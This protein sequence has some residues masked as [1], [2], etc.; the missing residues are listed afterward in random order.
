MLVVGKSI[1]AGVPLAAYGMRTEIASLI[2]PPEQSR[3][4]SGVVVG[5]VSTGG[6]LFANA[7]SM[8]A[9]RAALLEVL[10]E[11]AFE[12]TAALG[13]RMA[14][15]LRAAIARAGLGWS[16][17]QVGGHAYYFFE[18]AP[19]R[20][21]AG[22]RAADDP[23][24]ARADPRVHGQPRSLGIGM[25]AGADRVG[26]ARRVARRPL[27][28]VLRRVPE[29]GHV[30]TL[31]RPR[32]VAV[33]GGGIAGLT[34]AFELMRAGSE[35]TV[36]QLGWRLGG[37]GAS[38]RNRECGDRI[39]EHGLHVW[40]G[41]YA[42]AFELMRKVYADLGRPADAPLA[43]IDGA[44]APCD[45]LALWDRV[46]GA[47]HC[48]AF[49]MPR[50]G[51]HPWTHD[52]G[53]LPKFATV[54]KVAVRLLREAR[55]R[56]LGITIAG[57]E[58]DLELAQA[59]QL[60][61]EMAEGGITSQATSD[62]FVALLEAARAASA[63]GETQSPK[64]R[65]AHTTLDALA[66]LAKG[67]VMDVL[68]ADRGF[69]EIDDRE[70]SAWLADRGASPDTIGAS[71][72]E[73]APALR[74]LYDVAFC[75][76]DGD[77]DQDDAAAG[78]ATND[79]LRL[80]F[81]Y[82]GAI[83]YKMRAGMG[84]AVFAPLY[85]VL[86]DRGVTF[87][88]FNAVTQLGVA[89]DGRT[90]DRIDIVR[91]VGLREEDY[92]PLVGVKGLPCWP[93]EPRWEQLEDG[94][95]AYGTRYESEL[96]PRGVK[97][98][99]SL[100]LGRDFDDV[101]LAIPVGALE[102]ICGELMAACPRFRTMVERAE[103]VQTQSLQVWM[104]PGGARLG[105]RHPSEAVAACYVE[106]LDSYSDMSHLLKM[107]DHAP[108]DGSILYV[109]GVLKDIDGETR[110]EAERR[111]RA[112]VLSHVET[113]LGRV[114]TRAAEPGGNIWS[115]LFDPENRAGAARL[116]A[117]YWRANTAGWERYAIT[118]AGSV[119][120]RLAA[121][122]SGFGNLALAGDWTKNGING[123]CIEAAV[124]SGLQAARALGASPAVVGED[125]TWLQPG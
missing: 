14:V 75:F 76:R 77:I 59:E 78:T 20:D 86:R 61:T 56:L 80:L 24:L 84:D 19:P 85:E 63:R 9:G 82:R 96:D 81:T 30:M 29:R 62:A 115:T 67:I 70:W 79:L 17:A 8:A 21:A 41:F 83:S 34:A 11:D 69:D 54:M 44:F 26:R 4:V 18:P 52:P 101:V 87:R 66:A 39:E 33:L 120:W 22:S 51:G 88:F 37:K 15:G 16:V 122:E 109:C 50:R 36:Y 119:G 23:E 102:P 40:F 125:P 47:W 114:A 6:T 74:A 73:R 98:P 124:T 3:V 93:S 110:A 95:S 112:N 117:Q 42:N 57:D 113:D 100:C 1:A 31:E 10:T 35:V 32:K 27:R 68:F 111:V 48:H 89:D 94:A 28:R 12:R 55:K 108:A 46:D 58:A 49:R 5:E 90:I 13:D 123:G 65:L 118:P 7:L 45:D 107:E 25:V 103:T 53:E 105:Y 64:G 116:E 72:Q 71:F 60:A 2:A 104:L 97:V 121:H 43:T 106:P 99:E 92:D 91:Q 38:G